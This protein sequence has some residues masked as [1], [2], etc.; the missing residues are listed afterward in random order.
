[1]DIPNRFD[2]ESQQRMW[3]EALKACELT[4]ATP[5]E[6][7]ALDEA[8]LQAVEL[9]QA[10]A[11]LRVWEP[12]N[13]FVVLG[14]S[15][16][17]EKEVN[18]DVCES[19]NIP[20]LRRFSGGGT[21][22]VGPGCLCYTLAIPS[23]DFHRALGVS[24]VTTRLMERTAAGLSIHLSDIQVCGTSDLVWRGHKFSG[25]AQRW[26]RTSFVHHGTLLYDF[27]LPLLSRCLKQPSK[28]PDYR[29]SRGHNEFVTNIP[30]QSDQLQSCLRSAW[31]ATKT[32]CPNE[33]L[34]ETQRIVESKYGL[35]DWSVR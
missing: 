17:V 14:R 28:Q 26:L 6:N 21:V 29:Q 9:D 10:M 34:L 5:A 16:Q 18:V 31:N 22:L 13:Y 33:V 15:N 3:P 11:C 32:D 8:I 27:D 23:N 20:I 1:M 19:E 24:Q 4:L 2:A 25:N 35:K 12:T 7:L 30:L